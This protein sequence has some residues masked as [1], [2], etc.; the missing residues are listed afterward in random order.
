EA[1]QVRF[2]MLGDLTRVSRQMGAEAAGKPVADWIRAHGQEVDPA[3]WQSSR[4]NDKQMLFDLR[5]GTG[6][7]AQP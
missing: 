6:W 5:P 3:L 1:R 7:V 2:A 4:L